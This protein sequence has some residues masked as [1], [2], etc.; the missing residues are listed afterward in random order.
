MPPVQCLNVAP[1]FII[2]ENEMD[3]IV[4]ALDEAITEVCTRAER[5]A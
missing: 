1:P 4:A 3:E 2:D 5:A